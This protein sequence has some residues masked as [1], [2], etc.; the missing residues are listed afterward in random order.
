MARLAL[1]V[2][3]AAMATGMFI[4]KNRVIAL[5]NELEGINERIKEDQKAL[6]VLKAEWTYLNDPARIR[7]LST[8]HAAM[9]PIRGEQIISF[10]S[11][12]FKTPETQPDNDIIRVSF[13]TSVR[14]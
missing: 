10:S 11:I 2:I 9:K 6:H 7:S 8:R 12:P 14:E 4:I 1:I 5:E 13:A 3:F